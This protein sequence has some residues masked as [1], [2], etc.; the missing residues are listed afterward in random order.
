MTS[1]FPFLRRQWSRLNRQSE[2]KE[3]LGALHRSYLFEQTGTLL[4]CYVSKQ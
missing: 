2:S 1:I 3:S 4:T